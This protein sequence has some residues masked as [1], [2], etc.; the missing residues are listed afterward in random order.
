MVKWSCTGRGTCERALLSSI[1][2]LAASRH[3]VDSGHSLEFFLPVKTLKNVWRIVSNT[4]G[5][6]N[7]KKQKEH[8]YLR[9]RTCRGR[10]QRQR[11]SRAVGVQGRSRCCNLCS[12]FNTFYP[13]SC[14]LYSDAWMMFPCCYERVWPAQCPAAFWRVRIM[15]GPNC[16]FNFC[17]R[18]K[19]ALMFDSSAFDLDVLTFFLLGDFCSCP[20]SPFS[21]CVGSLLDSDLL[22]LQ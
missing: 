4:K 11:D 17:S 18:L 8:I 13:H 2:S 7:C 15:S 19:T 20:V 21:P 12:G 10:Q 6:Q 22:K 3:T 1:F 5:T 14:M 16:H 9:C